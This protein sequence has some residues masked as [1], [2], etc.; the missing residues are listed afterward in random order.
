M[1]TAT[2]T[3]ITTASLKRRMAIT[4]ADDDTLVGEIV[5]GVNQFIET[6]SGRILSP[7]TL[8]AVTFD[9][10]EALEDG[11][12]F[13]FPWGI[14]TI[15]LLEI[16]PNTGGTFTTVAAGDIFLRPVATQRESGWPATEIWISD[17]PSSSTTYPYFPAGFGNVRITGTGGWAAEPDDI[18]AVGHN[19][20]VTDYR[21]RSAAGGDRFTIGADGART[22]ERMLTAKDRAILDRYRY[23]KVVVV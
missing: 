14:Q 19:L 16:A 7:T 2:G 8:T 10:Y 9:G 22:Y 1:A 6:Y 13:P 17:I 12:L 5:D 15:S 18:I 4:D 23:R 20:G 11:R 3:Y 21:G